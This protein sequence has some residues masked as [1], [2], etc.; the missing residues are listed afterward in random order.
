M[1]PETKTWICTVCGYR[2]EGEEPPEVCPDC[3]APKDK[4]VEL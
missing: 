3:G 2:H 4:F 1:A